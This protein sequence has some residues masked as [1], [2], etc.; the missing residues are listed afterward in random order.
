MSLSTTD[1]TEV[2]KS[3]PPFVAPVYGK[4][5]GWIPKKEAHFCDGGAYP[6]I[7]VAQFPLSMGRKD[8]QQQRQQANSG[9]NGAGTLALSVS[10]DGEVQYDQIV[11]QG[12]RKDK[13][14]YSK[15]SD[16]IESVEKQDE[17]SLAKPSEG[18]EARI[19]QETRAALENKLNVK[20]EVF[21]N[22][23]RRK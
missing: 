23:R 12:Q 5:K 21:I 22:L 1:G 14:V 19:A 13:I 17:S 9:G 4:R 10:K 16:L 7:H 2:K 8:R 15:F 20:M 11:K 6:E 18:E 3:T